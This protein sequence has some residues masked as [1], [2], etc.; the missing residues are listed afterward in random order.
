VYK[1]AAGVP[2]AL[3][4]GTPS[5]VTVVAGDNTFDVSP[6]VSIPQGNYWIAVRGFGTAVATNGL[7]I[8][9]AGPG[10]PTAKRC[11]GENTSAATDPWALSAITGYGNVTCFTASTDDL[12]VFNL[13]ITT[14]HQNP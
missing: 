8:F 10:E 12:S 9:K 7:H 1:D 13:W 14:Y 3:L 11:A 5:A 6:D 4:A 2:G